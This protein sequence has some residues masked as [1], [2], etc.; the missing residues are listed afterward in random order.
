MGLR[1]Q[2][3]GKLQ[4]HLEDFDNIVVDL[5]NLGKKACDE[6]KDMLFLLNSLAL[7]YQVLKQLLMYRDLTSN[8][9]SK[10][11]SFL[12][13]LWHAKEIDT[14]SINNII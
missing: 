8:F 4:D 10:I 11:M 7:F 14:V 13:V 1:L 2:K 9:Y 6:Q 5:M 12:V 3:G